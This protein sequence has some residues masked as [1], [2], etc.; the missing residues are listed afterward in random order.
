MFIKQDKVSRLFYL[1]NASTLPHST[2]E[3]GELVGEMIESES[4]AWKAVKIIVKLA[5]SVDLV[6]F[7]ES[8]FCKTIY[9]LWLRLYREKST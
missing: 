6:V 1:F 2:K 5:L 3:L 7:F 8:S 4:I 9:V